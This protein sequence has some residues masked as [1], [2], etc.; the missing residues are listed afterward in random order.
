MCRYGNLVPRTEYGKIVTI[1]YAVFGIPVYILYFMNMGK[2]FARL[3]KWIYTQLYNIRVRR[4]ADG[5]D[6]DTMENEGEIVEILEG[7]VEQEVRQTIQIFHCV[8]LHWFDQI[9][10]RQDPSAMVIILD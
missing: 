2:V 8:R 6:Y 4:A 3:F 7:Q 5:M 9:E 10:M 1:V